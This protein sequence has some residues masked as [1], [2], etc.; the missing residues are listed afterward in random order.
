MDCLWRS[1]SPSRLPDTG[2]A[3]SMIIIVKKQEVAG[4]A[5]GGCTYDTA[6]R[7]TLG[8]FRSRPTTEEEK[9]AI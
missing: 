2:C 5:S 3:L 7:Y 8:G 1:G 9:E 6:T 4:T